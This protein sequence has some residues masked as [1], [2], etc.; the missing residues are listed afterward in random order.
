MRGLIGEEITKPPYV[1]KERPPGDPEMFPDE[2]RMAELTKCSL[3]VTYFVN[4]YIQIL[5]DRE[6]KWIRFTLY[7]AQINV[8]ET[9]VNEKYVI[10]LKTRQFGATTLVAAY[11]AWLSLFANNASLLF[12]SKSEREASVLMEDRYK[13]MFRRLPTW[14]MPKED[15]SLPDSKSEIGLSNGA[16]TFSLPTS[17]GDSYTARA[18][19]VD[20]AALVYKSKTSLSDVLLAVQPTMAAGGQLFLVS[21]ADKSRPS[22]TF[23]GI[24]TGAMNGDNEFFPIFAPW[25]A[26]PWRTREWYDRQK[27]LS[28]S[29]DGT[30]DSVRENYPETPEEALS[31][32][33]LDKRL[34][35]KLIAPNFVPSNGLYGDDVAEHEVPEVPNLLL[36]KLP[37]PAGTYIMTADPAE[38][39]PTSDFSCI[40][41]WDWDT[42]EQMANV[43]GRF[44]P[45]IL[46]LYIDLLSKFFNGAPVFPE[47]NNHGGSLVLALRVSGITRIL[48]GPDEKEGYNVTLKSKA[49]G[50]TELAT[51]LRE[52]K[53]IIHNRE[54]YRQ[55]Q[56]I[57]GSTLRAPE[58][59]HDDLATTAML[60][61]AA[62]KFVHLSMLIEFV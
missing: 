36:Y 30:M 12:L 60:Y 27:Q 18:V 52:K 23:N 40:D 26:V 49:I 55:L 21:K 10:L 9:L 62:K 45:S 5:D 58:G 31:P 54:T 47:R 42:G 4:N 29:I 35:Y 15:L 22:S 1:I 13:P 7:P 25:Y 50:F 34:H 38:G 56:S 28:L 44:E 2:M 33:E 3:S 43:A 46:A 16:K 20:E 24:F 61:A 41:V 39:N 48:S 17:G 8:L 53:M 51:L 14:M 32:K 57:E 11:F 19:L 59:D 6:R 37:D